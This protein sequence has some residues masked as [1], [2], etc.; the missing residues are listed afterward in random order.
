MQGSMPKQCKNNKAN[1]KIRCTYEK[2]SK[3]IF[4]KKPG[5][6]LVLKVLN[7]WSHFGSISFSTVS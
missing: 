6:D 7:Y 4:S 1:R 2:V 3:S 5:S